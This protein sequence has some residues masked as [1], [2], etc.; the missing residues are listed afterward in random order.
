MVDG[1]P[2]HVLDA[3]QHLV[4]DY[5]GGAASLAPRLG[6]THTTLCNEVTGRHG[7]KFGLQDSVKASV[8]ADD[9]R[10]LTAFA[11]AMR[12]TVLRLPDVPEV[13]GDALAH[14]SAL[15]EEFGD[16]TRTFVSSIADGR[17]TANEIAEPVK[18][19]GE[20]QAAGQHLVAYAHA[21]H[22]AGKPAF[23]R[24]QEGVRD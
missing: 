12:C 10:I 17:V 11:A 19:W 4:H 22:E 8:F 15:A 6:K 14:V 5:P 20:L 18:Q 13:Q 9:L 7:Y 16:V 21:M 2:M 23:I 1:S 3:A 24:E